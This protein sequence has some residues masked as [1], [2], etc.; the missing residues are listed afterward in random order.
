MLPRNKKER[1]GFFLFV[2]YI[3]CIAMI[4]SATFAMCMVLIFDL[5]KMLN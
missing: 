2:F 1:F 4:V 3:F 5:L